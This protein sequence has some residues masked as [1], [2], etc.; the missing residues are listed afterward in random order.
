MAVFFICFWSFLCP[1]LGLL[2]FGVSQPSAWG[3]SSTRP[4]PRHSLIATFLSGVSARSCLSLLRLIILLFILCF[5]WFPYILFPLFIFCFAGFSCICFSISLYCF[6]L[7]VC[8]FFDFYSFTDL[9]C[10]YFVILHPLSG[11]FPRLHRVELLT[12]PSVYGV[13]LH[14][15]SFIFLYFFVFACNKSCLD[16]PALG[17]DAWSRSLGCGCE[18]YPGFR[19]EE[20]KYWPGVP[21]PQCQE[22]S[23]GLGFSAFSVKE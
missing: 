16:Q 5:L 6:F 2:A 7:F 19:V 3:K 10:V 15:I 12:H 21:G 17:C 8:V 4:L 13:Y 22:I 14:V 18:R 20:D 11:L 1:C 9:L 23:V